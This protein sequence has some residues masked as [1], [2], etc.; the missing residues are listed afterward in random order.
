MCPGQL[1]L[2]SFANLS[3]SLFS[4]VLV[5]LWHGGEHVYL[6]GVSM[7]IYNICLNEKTNKMKKQNKNKNKKTKNKKQKTKN[8]KQK[9][10]KI[11]KIKTKN[12]IK[13]ITKKQKKNKKSQTCGCCSALFQAF[14]VCWSSCTNIFMILQ[15]CFKL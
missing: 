1:H 13:N 3:L 6:Q 9:Q 12:K 14:V 15:I 2:N 8:K 11:K 7:S 4:S 5:C 10:K